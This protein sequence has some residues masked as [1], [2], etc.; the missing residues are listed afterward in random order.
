M[1]IFVDNVGG[2][3]T[4]GNDPATAFATIQQALDDA[5]ALTEDIFVHVGASNPHTETYSASQTLSSSQADTVENAIHVYGVDFN[6]SNAF[7]PTPST[8]ITFGVTASANDITI[9][10]S[11]VWNGIYF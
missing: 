4:T 3:D 1:T 10:A 5:G 2:D 8:A 6:A 7:V 11:V 9:T